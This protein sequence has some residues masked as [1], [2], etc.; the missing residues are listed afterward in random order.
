VTI[1]LRCTIFAH[2]YS[3]DYKPGKH[4]G[5]IV[6]EK[7]AYIG[8]HCVIFNDVTIGEGAVVAAGSVV[9]RNVPPGVLFGPPQAAPIARVTRPL[10]KGESMDYNRFVFGLK[11]L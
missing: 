6:F 7:N 3:G 8:P 1:G 5:K 11:R 9:S 4:V 2:F 10:I